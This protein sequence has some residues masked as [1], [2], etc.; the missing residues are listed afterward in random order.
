MTPAH[1]VAVRIGGKIMVDNRIEVNFEKLRLLLDRTS[2]AF[3]ALDS[4]GKAY[5]DFVKDT[6]K[7]ESQDN[8]IDLNQRR[9]EKDPNE[10]YN[11][12]E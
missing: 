7:V 10:I 2:D 6:F 9:L 5:D 3:H 12:K 11:N 1:F 4:M 8:I